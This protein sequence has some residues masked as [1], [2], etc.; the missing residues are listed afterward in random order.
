MNHCRTWSVC[1]TVSLAEAFRLIVASDQYL[2]SQLTYP[3]M[4]QDATLDWGSPH[5]SPYS[6]QTRPIACWN[7]VT[8]VQRSKQTGIKNPIQ[9][10]RKCLTSLPVNRD[11]GF[12]P[13][14][15]SMAESVVSP[16]TTPEK[17]DPAALPNPAAIVSNSPPLPVLAP[18]GTWPPAATMDASLADWGTIKPQA[19]PMR[20]P[21]PLATP[22]TTLR[23]TSGTGD[24]EATTARSKIEEMPWNFIVVVLRA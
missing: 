2:F 21:A 18:P 3:N 5:F 24:A 6:F 10:K 16:G 14:A 12:W 11:H 13:P 4:F 9:A 8:R 15:A 1:V 7:S 22:S 23:S 20:L 19:P 17:I